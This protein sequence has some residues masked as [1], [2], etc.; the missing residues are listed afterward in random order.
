MGSNASSFVRAVGGWLSFGISVQRP[1]T[2]LHV[3]N[4]GVGAAGRY[5]SPNTCR[6]F[7]D[8]GETAWSLR[9]FCAARVPHR[10]GASARTA[11]KPGFGVNAGAGEARISTW[12]IT[13]EAAGPPL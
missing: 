12:R 1:I 11:Q 7:G 10:A 2:A 5:K 8:R 6:N 13:D 4:P 9:H 3:G